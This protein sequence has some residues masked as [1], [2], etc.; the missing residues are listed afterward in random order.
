MNNFYIHCFISTILL[1]PFFSVT[2]PPNDSATIK[3]VPE[4][5]IQT[6]LFIYLGTYSA[7][8]HVEIKTPMTHTRPVWL[9]MTTLLLSSVLTCASLFCITTH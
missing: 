4:D 8:Y 6:M 7:F 5:M 9:Q 1:A 2:L 3:A